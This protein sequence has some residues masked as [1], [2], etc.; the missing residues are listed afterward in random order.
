MVAFTSRIEDLTRKDR[1]DLTKLLCRNP[2]ENINRDW[3][4]DQT[5]CLANFPKNML[6]PSGIVGMVPRLVMALP[7]ASPN[8][9]LCSTHKALNPQLIHRI[10]MELTAESTIYLT[11]LTEDE[12][13]KD[14]WI[15]SFLYRMQKLNSLWM[16]PDSYRATFEAQ[17]EDPRFEAVESGCEACIVASVG[18]SKTILCDL[19]AG[20]R[21]RRKRMT[22]APL[23]TKLVDAW[24]DWNPDRSRIVRRSDEL[25]QVIHRRRKETQRRRRARRHP[26]WESVET[27][28]ETVVNEDIHDVPED[29]LVYDPRNEEQEY[30][31][32]GSIIDFYAHRM[33]GS[34]NLAGLHPALSASTVLLTNMGTFQPAPPPLPV[35]T[36]NHKP[37]YIES[38][39]SEAGPSNANFA[40]SNDNRRPS[41][42]ESVLRY[43]QFDM[44][45]YRA[46]VGDDSGSESDSGAGSDAREYDRSSRATKRTTWSAFQRG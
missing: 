30:D 43:P 40:T 10:F 15:Q 42:A 23:L 6:R 22:P 1:R 33:R 32:E 18:G 4:Q 26:S 44:D 3:L 16:S 17:P 8:A 36:V 24:I 29:K 12:D 39:Y 9:I 41:A 37:T 28:S 7:W 25:G 34:G 2:N 5:F 14:G 11:T 19:R 13:D 20:M 21:G 31:F 35:R 38:M 27:R 45:T 46:L